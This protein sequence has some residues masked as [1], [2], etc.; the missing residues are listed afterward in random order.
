MSNQHRGLSLFALTMIAIGATIGSGIFKTPA[1]IAAKVGDNQTIIL[2][3]IM[4]GVVSLLGA[5]VFAELGSRFSNAGGVYT[6]LNKAYGPLPGFL[7]GWCLLTVI[8]SGTIAALCTVFAENLG[9]FIHIPDGAQKYV[10][11]ATIAVLT[12]FNTFGIKLSEWFANVGTVLKIVGI[13]SLLILALMLGDKALFA[14]EAVVQAGS[15]TPAADNLAGAFVGVL[16]S[17]TGWHY[18]SFVSGDAI[19]PKRNIPLAMILGTGAVTLTYV[20]CNLG[21]FKVID[22][23]TIASFADSSNPKVVAVEVMNVIMPAASYLMPGLIAL[24]V[25][26]CAGL[27]I[28]STPR[29][30]NQMATEGL[31][32]SAFAKKDP[33]FGVPVNAIILQ[34]A[35][36]MILVYLWGSFSSIIEYVT[37]VEWLFLLTACVGIFIVRKKYAHEEAPFR[38]PFYPVIPLLFI[39]VIGW[40]IFKNALADKAEYYAGLAVI[41][42]GVFVYYLFKRK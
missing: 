6:Y 23:N 10:A 34:S 31:F 5:L 19:N 40:F 38:V 17:Y 21:Y 35:W 42:V 25:F 36:A 29:I 14:A 8:S 9:Y 26:A 12:L 7:Y 4:G 20:L 16:W 13:Y 24:S 33:R 22:H 41:P 39:A 3:W 32:F 11:M 2:L 27:Y 37:F 15:A 30:F 28:L 1:G 18:A